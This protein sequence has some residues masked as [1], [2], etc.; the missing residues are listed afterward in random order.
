LVA[1]LSLC[2]HLLFDFLSI[3]DAKDGK[4]LK[5]QLISASYL[6]VMIFIFDYSMGKFG[7]KTAQFGQKR[8]HSGSKSNPTTWC[9][10]RLSSKL[11]RWEADLQ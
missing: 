1:I 5:D 9:C 10:H 4:N 8:D 3:I 7:Q 2:F 6:V 11:N